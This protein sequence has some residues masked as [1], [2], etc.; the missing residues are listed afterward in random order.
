MA[1]AERAQR[2]SAFIGLFPRLHTIISGTLK[3]DSA[4]EIS[5]Y[6]V[7]MIQER[8]FNGVK[9]ANTDPVDFLS[10]FMDQMNNNPEV[11]TFETGVSMLSSNLAAGSDTTGISLGSIFFH[12][13]QEPRCV[14]RL[15]EDINTAYPRK[16]KDELFTFKEAQE[17]P[18]L[19]AI[20]KEALRLHPAGG[21]PLARRVP[22]G[23]ATISGV[24]FPEGVRRPL[25]L[26]HFLFLCLLHLVLSLS[27]VQ[28]S[29]LANLTYRLWSE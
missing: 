15:L 24:H 18:Y 29:N 28:D 25:N 9:T 27:Q 10:L 19:Q 26:Y 4:S 13:M 1:L 3:L 22:K 12:L 17:L 5:K 23:G 14:Q 8:Q 16:G 6:A 11:Y 7:R 20:I 21:M 2:Y